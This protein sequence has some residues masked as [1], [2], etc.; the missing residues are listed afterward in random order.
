[1]ANHEILDKV[2]INILEKL[3]KIKVFIK[4]I[5]MLTSQHCVKNGIHDENEKKYRSVIIM[6]FIAFMH[7]YKAT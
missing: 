5:L 2:K 7:T 3:V 4:K 6:P 1:M